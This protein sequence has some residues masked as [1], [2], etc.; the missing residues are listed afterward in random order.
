MYYKN[1]L[2]RKIYGRLE[3]LYIDYNQY[4]LNKLGIKSIGDLTLY[5]ATKIRSSKDL[6]VNILN[7]LD[8]LDVVYDI[9]KYVPVDNFNKLGVNY[10]PSSMYTASFLRSKDYILLFHKV[11]DKLDITRKRIKG[12]FIVDLTNTDFVSYYT[13]DSSYR[14]V[15]KG[16]NKCLFN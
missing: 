11:N 8:C 12:L 14:K 9:K 1:S 7:E 10:V 4:C 6:E 5:L 16:I 2:D 13:S 3:L 15:V